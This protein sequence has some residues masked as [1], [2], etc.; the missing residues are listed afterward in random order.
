M[1]EKEDHKAD[2]PASAQETPLNM[3]ALLLA[4][5]HELRCYHNTDVTHFVIYVLVVADNILN[6]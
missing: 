2:V 3:R 4:A 1:G 6:V 5:K